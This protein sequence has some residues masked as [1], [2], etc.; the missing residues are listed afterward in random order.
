MEVITHRSIILAQ[1]VSESS[2]EFQREIN[3]F[4]LMA[5]PF[6]QV[7]AEPDYSSL[8]GIVPE[9]KRNANA[10]ALGLSER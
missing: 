3:I 2:H 1:N 9:W 7:L 4:F 6:R 8:F 10:I 5:C